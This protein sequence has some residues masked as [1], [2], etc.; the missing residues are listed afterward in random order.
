[1][2]LGLKEM[3]EDVPDADEFE[4]GDEQKS[5]YGCLDLTLSL[6]MWTSFVVFLVYFFS[7]DGD[8]L[9]AD[10][11]VQNG[12]DSFLPFCVLLSS[13]ALYLAEAFLFQ[14]CIHGILYELSY[15][16]HAPDALLQMKAIREAWPSIKFYIKCYHLDSD[17][18]KV[19]THTVT[20]EY[21][22]QNWKDVSELSALEDGINAETVLRRKKALL[23]YNIRYEFKG[24]DAIS[25]D[26]FKRETQNFFERNMR[27]KYQQFETLYSLST[28]QPT[29]LVIKSEKSDN[30]WWFSPCTYVLFTLLGLT[31]PYRVYIEQKIDR[32]GWT[33]IK[34]YTLTRV[35][36]RQL[37]L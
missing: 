4:W 7:S 24:S 23:V 27:D 25:E 15:S 33:N 22:I 20:Q 5:H 18:K 11:E 9:F 6:F 10:G 32:R 14:C 16:M 19:V 13:V 34:E 21:L 30:N 1:M 35:F 8:Q 29:H 36:P 37:P 3:D 26:V 28:A 2:E 17:N 12:S 31:F